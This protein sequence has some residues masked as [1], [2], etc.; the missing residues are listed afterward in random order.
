M[1]II[2]NSDARAV[3]LEH[4][5]ECHGFAKQLVEND[6]LIEHDKI[7]VLLKHI[8]T[9]R[10]LVWF[11]INKYL[12]LEQPSDIRD[13]FRTYLHTGYHLTNLKNNPTSNEAIVLIQDFNRLSENINS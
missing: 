2:L 12:N 8:E 10:D 9:H 11:M 4:L 6:V 1:T 13:I 7:D 3:I 5:D